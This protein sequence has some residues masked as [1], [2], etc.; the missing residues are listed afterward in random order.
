LH[1][2]YPIFQ[3]YFTCRNIFI[4]WF[5]TILL[6]TH[7]CVYITLIIQNP[8]RP[9]FL[10][11]IIPVFPLRP[12]NQSEQCREISRFSFLIRDLHTTLFFL[13]IP[14]CSARSRAQFHPQYPVWQIKFRWRN[15]WKINFSYYIL[16]IRASR[17]VDDPMAIELQCNFCSLGVS[18]FRDGRTDTFGQPLNRLAALPV[19]FCCLI[20]WQI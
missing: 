2:Q 9:F 10:F 11:I 12:S 17:D 6:Y 3:M 13:K 16:Q 1:Q 7:Y 20:S 4:T 19:D 5:T 18:H 15:N 14:S 8:R